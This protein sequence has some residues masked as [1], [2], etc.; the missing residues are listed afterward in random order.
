MFL[1]HISNAFLMTWT[2]LMERPHMK[3]YFR[4]KRQPHKYYQGVPVKSD[5]DNQV[6]TWRL[7]DIIEDLVISVTAAE[8][9]AECDPCSPF[10]AISMLKKQPMI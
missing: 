7:R 9:L 2:I 4:S 10:E 8:L 1:Q 6:E 3:H 5:P